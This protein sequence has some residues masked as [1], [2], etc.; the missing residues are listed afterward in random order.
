MKVQQNKSLNQTLTMHF[1]LTLSIRKSTC[2][3]Q[4]SPRSTI[5]TKKQHL[6]SNNEQDLTVQLHIHNTVMMQFSPDLEI[7]KI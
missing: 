1:V 5:T 2:C 4:D 3:Q 7:K 6:L